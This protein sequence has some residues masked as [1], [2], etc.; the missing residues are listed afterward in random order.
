MKTVPQTKTNEKTRHV[1]MKIS[2]LS[3]KLYSDHTGH[4]PVTLSQGNFY[5]VIFYTVD[6]NHIKSYP[7][8]S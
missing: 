2:N 6:G 1:C 8:E 5:A 3:G 4:F 7:I